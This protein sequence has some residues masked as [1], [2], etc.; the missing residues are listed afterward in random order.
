M[1]D[2]DNLA[3]I[4]RRLRD[5][6]RF[7]LGFEPTLS[8]FEAWRSD[9]LVQVARLI[10]AGNC[11]VDS[12]KTVERWHLPSHDASRLDVGFSNGENT[13]AFLLQPHGQ[14]PAPAVLLL[15]DHGATFDIG[16]EKV[17]PPPADDAKDAAARAW[18]QRFYGG[19]FPGEEL[20][21]LGYVVLCV[22]ALGWG[23]RCGNG[24]EAQQALAAN[25]M[26]F[27]VSLA[28]VVAMEDVAAARFLASLPQVDSKRVASFGFSF[29]GYRA[30]Q[31]A[32]LSSDVSAF[33]A[34]SWMGT[35]KGLMQ[36]GGNQLRGQ[37]AFYMLH[38]QIAGKL[39][40]PDFAGLAAPKPAYFL[41]GSEDTHFPPADVADAFARLCELW[42][43]AGA[44]QKLTTRIWEGGHRLPVAEQDAA[45]DWLGAV[46]RG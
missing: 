35:L 43:A 16:K 21:R 37:S 14:A 24:Y 5:A 34:A 11:S 32:A 10:D 31:V 46:L 6:S 17:I 23:S 18:S 36:T 30:W 41:S 29:G 42:A 40:Y 13:Q 45:I 22:D 4:A 19:R 27:G 38:P 20:A 25:L 33:F 39:D 12:V 2:H 3:A 8:S 9:T 15:H 1:I 26:Q 44:E 28:S 7:S